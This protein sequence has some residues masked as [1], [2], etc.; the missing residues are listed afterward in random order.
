MNFTGK[1]PVV[2]VSDQTNNP[3]CT[4]KG[5]GEGAAVARKIKLIDFKWK[6]ATEVARRKDHAQTVNGLTFSTPV[7]EGT[8][9]MVIESDS[10]ANAVIAAVPPIKGTVV[11]FAHVVKNS[12]A[13]LNGDWAYE[14]GAECAAGEGNEYKLTLPIV[15]YLNDDGT[16]KT[17]TGAGGVLTAAA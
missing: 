8:A 17:L 15:R 2:G 13:H 5:V 3:T 10:L 9:E 16:Y 1:V 7:E 14:G 12:L 6:D 4:Y 11:A